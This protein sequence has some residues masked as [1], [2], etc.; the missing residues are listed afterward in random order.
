M[1][2]N[3]TIKKILPQK[4]GDQ[5]AW[6]ELYGNRLALS[7]AEAAT[8]IDQPLL[9]I[10]S[11]HYLAQQLQSL[12]QYYLAEQHL[13]VE[14]FPDWEILAFD[15]FS[16]HQDIISKR[17][18]L[19][20]QLPIKTQGIV[21][22]TVS[23][24]L[25]RFCPRDFIQQHSLLLQI[26]EK[27][28][29]IKM[30]EN[31]IKAGY[32]Q[33][34][35]VLEHGEFTLRGSLLDIF[36]MGSQ[37]PFRI[38]FFA[39]EIDS[40]RSFDP[41]TQLSQEKI[42]KIAILPAH[43]FPLNETAIT[44]FRQN[45]RA[46]FEG[47]PNE[48]TIY[49]AVSNGEAPAGIEYYLALFFEKTTNLLNYLPE[50]S[51]IFKLGNIA[52]TITAF[53]AEVN[54][55][56][57]QLRHDYQRPILSPA[58]IFLAENEFYSSL[59]PF[60]QV[61]L[62][63]EPITNKAGHLN[64]QSQMLPDIKIES[65]DQAFLKLKKFLRNNPY[66]I[67]FTAE[68]PGRLQILREQLQLHSIK[69]D[70]VA[71]WQAFIN[72][73]ANHQITTSPIYQGFIDPT[74]QIAVI[75]ENELL[76]ERVQS[77][78]LSKKVL[79]PEAIIRNLVELHVGDPVVHIDYGVGRYLGL[80]TLETN[81]I[82]S[83]F[84]HIE[85]AGNDKLYVPVANLQ[86]ISR[87]TGGDPEHA[88]L[89]RLG[90]KKW[91]QNIEKATARIRDV[92]AEL[93]EIY[94]T[95]EMKS[96]FQF[97]KPSADYFEFC[98][99]FPFDETEDQLTAINQV[100]S[101]MQSKKCMDRLVCGDV[102]FGKTEVAMRAA[103]LAVASHKQVAILVPTTLLAEQHSKNFQD[104]FAN[105]PV[106]IADISRFVSPA[107]QT[108]I[109][110]QLKAGKIDI[111][112]GTHKLIQANIKFKDLGL[113]IIDEEHRFGVKQKEKIKALKTEVDVLTLTATPIPRTL[114][115]ALSGMRDLSM[116]TTP[117]ALRLAIKTFVQVYHP[118]IVREAMLREI[119]RGGQVYFVY[120]RVAD[121]EKI[122]DELKKLVPEA[123]IE[124]AHGQMREKQLEKVMTDFYHQKFN[125]LVA[126]T[127]IESG[128]DVPNANTMIIH[129]AERFGLAQIHQL[130]GRVGRSHHQA[131]AYLLTADTNIL[132]E[133]AKKRL[134][135]ISKAQ[136]LGAGF[137]LASHDLEIRGAGELLGDEQSGHIQ[138]IGFSLY[139]EM[140]EEA[141]TAL[142]QGRE[143]VFKQNSAADTVVDLQLSALIP[144]DYILD[145]NLRL[146]L[147][148]R[149]ADC[150]NTLALQA[151]KIE[152][153]DRFGPLPV[154]TE[155]LLQ[156]TA[157]KIKA[158]AL[159]I[160]KI[161]S[162]G[163]FA[164]IYFQSKPQINIEA[165]LNLIQIHSKNYKMFGNERLRMQIDHTS[166]QQQL[167]A[168][169][170]LLDKLKPK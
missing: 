47:N 94:A 32:R 147:Y 133:D 53:Y 65:G 170:N 88:P 151:L 97:N 78:K 54:A 134:Q 3:L 63:A 112:I 153:I 82:T 128:I 4:I 92:A 66:K 22:A 154:P 127:I 59:K 135:A 67:L 36:P 18:K 57:E 93:V 83:E 6:G 50:N 169:D 52:E 48:A 159:G 27:F 69:T 103:F 141:V 61:Q 64:F 91:Q 107:E 95:R 40:I 16:P 99:Q 119:F 139:L 168:I 24:M 152:F 146:T 164:N 41:D 142:K 75:S 46:R 157:L 167:S 163:P 98:N 19:L 72:H 13:S 158:K 86:L 109:L 160:Q 71:T 42:E 10:C 129:R 5:R 9:I 155:N 100:L 116:I 87:Y 131:Y 84:L 143:P 124:I 85:Y 113:L 166:A 51:L 115:L 121:I 26:K 117:P 37:T 89:D 70:E 55:R 156:Q 34:N 77:K 149:L 101:D 1:H 20:Y 102:G 140:L 56:Y 122:A 76:G 15:H 114:N 118:Q 12:L 74:K 104:R 136:T 21:I 126:T 105:W 138:A 17:V 162:S 68:S 23:T 145:I 49:T 132:T 58:E 33:V 2:T 11:D 120:N 144:S 110:A 106:Q 150:K 96:G 60:R 44:L 7:I 31:F 30:R 25:H 73:P 137:L 123:R 125:V 43:E 39:D 111:I 8:E 35:Q 14:I 81:D 29:T 165:L 148:K 62:Q 45:W 130:R 38:D 79:D 80:K 108:K 90:S 161:S 28:D